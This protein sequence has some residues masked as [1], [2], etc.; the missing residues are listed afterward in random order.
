MDKAVLL[1][2]ISI[3]LI[4]T[5]KNQYVYKVTTKNVDGSYDTVG[6]ANCIYDLTK[7]IEKK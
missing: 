7:P 2:N 4:K 1:N 3:A 5:K 6:F